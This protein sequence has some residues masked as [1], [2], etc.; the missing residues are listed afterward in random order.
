MSETTFAKAQPRSLLDYSETPFTV[1]AGQSGRVRTLRRIDA[2]TQFVDSA[3]ASCEI[4][5]P[6][7]V[8]LGWNVMPMSPETSDDGTELRDRSLTAL[9]EIRATLGLSEVK[10]AALVGIARNT[11]ASWRRHERVPY[12]ATVRT[13]FEV[14]SIVAAATALLEHAGAQQWFLGYTNEGRARLDILGSP[15][16]VQTLAAELRSALFPATAPSTLPNVHDFNED[17]NDEESIYAP[18]VFAGEIEL[19]PDF[20]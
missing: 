6:L 4:G 16:G 19:D 11:L 3:L 1:T 20:G 8:D 13:L 5:T 15:D 9:D 7:P 10:L 12:P 18:E 2:I 14:H 17:G